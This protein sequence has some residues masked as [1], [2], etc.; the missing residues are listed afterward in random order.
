MN[1]GMLL[2][3][4]PRETLTYLLYAV[5]GSLLTAALL[6]IVRLIFQKALSPMA[7]Y[8]LWI[9]LAVRLLL[10]VLPP[11]PVSA[12]NLLPNSQ[13]I[14]QSLE[15]VVEKA[16]DHVPIQL[17][18]RNVSSPGE[19]AMVHENDVLGTLCRLWCWG[20]LLSGTLY[21]AAYIRNGQKLRRHPTVTDE[22]TIRTFQ[23]LRGAMGIPDRITLRS[24]DRILIGGLRH[25][26]LLI[27]RELSGEPL[28]AALTHELMHYAGKDLWVMA[29][30]R[31][32]LCVY[33]FDPVVWLCFRQM[34]RDCEKA[35]DHAVLNRGTVSP[36]RYGELLYA[37]G[38]M[39][40]RAEIGTTAFVGNHLKSRIK[41]LSGYQ[42]PKGW[43]TV[44]A[45]VLG[46]AIS[47][48]TL[49]GAREIS[50]HPADYLHGTVVQAVFREI[51]NGKSS[52]FSERQKTQLMEQLKTVERFDMERLEERV[53]GEIAVEITDKTD[54]V[55]SVT[56]ESGKVFNFYNME[57]SKLL[58]RYTVYKGGDIHDT[59]WWTIE[60]PT[61]HAFLGEAAEVAQ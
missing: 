27:P 31:L 4:D 24:G 39:D 43:M 21:I 47:V 36:A 17:S 2:F 44:L 3:F 51:S 35:C 12:E 53:P 28:E 29:L 20:F 59:Y 58:L 61:L 15:A 5:L 42:R 45:V 19:M 32:L 11:S 46:V 1:P 34:K 60:S 25:P 10:P 26:V 55:L 38:K 54:S 18:E 37:E 33:W 56:F 49:T 52:S 57:N 48:C 14:Q 16:A 41:A 22:E 9:P 30:W 50:R 40:C 23:T 13:R 6:V 8:L 7:K